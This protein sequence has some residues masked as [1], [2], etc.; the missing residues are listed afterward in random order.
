MKEQHSKAIIWGIV[1]VALAIIIVAVYILF[2][3][4][5]TSNKSLDGKSDAIAI[6]G[7][8]ELIDQDGNVFNSD[9]LKGKLSLIY[10]GFTFCPDVCPESL[11]KLSKVL[12]VLDKY[13]ID[14]NTVFITI[15]PNRDTKGLL[16]EYLRHFHPKIIGLTGTEDQIKEAADKFKVYYAKTGNIGSNDYMMDHTTFI[17]LLDKNGKYL[18]HFYLNSSPESIVEC[19]RTGGK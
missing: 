19:I 1:T 18:R 4:S 12:N 2:A 3:F 15:D 11:N 16:K 13:N 5:D 17:Y 7:D 14:V 8:F 10:F 9:K 6:G